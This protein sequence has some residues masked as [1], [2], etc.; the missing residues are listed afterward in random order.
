MYSKKAIEEILN[1]HKRESNQLY[2]DYMTDAVTIDCVHINHARITS[3]KITDCSS[4]HDY[5][6]KYVGI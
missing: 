2:L 4:K 3:M 1:C 5:I 6:L